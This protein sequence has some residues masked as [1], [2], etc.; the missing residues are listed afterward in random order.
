[1]DGSP[2]IFHDTP[3]VP[4]EILNDTGFLIDVDP[5]DITADVLNDAALVPV[6][7]CTLDVDLEVLVVQQL[8]R[9]CPRSWQKPFKSM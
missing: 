1:M 2:E 9:C 6:S 4:P 7:M 3:D 5:L 8:S